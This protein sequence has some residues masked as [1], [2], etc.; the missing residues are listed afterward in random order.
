V[1]D[2]VLDAEMGDL[3]RPRISARQSVNPP[4]RGNVHVTRALVLLR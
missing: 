1:Q 2:P 3:L 4:H